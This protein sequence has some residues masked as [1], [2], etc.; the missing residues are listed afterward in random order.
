MFYCVTKRAYRRLDDTS[1]LL[2]TLYGS[3][4]ISVCLLA[5]LR[6]I[7][8]PCRHFLCLVCLYRLCC[9]RLLFAHR[10]QMRLVCPARQSIHLCCISQRTCFLADSQGR[11]YTLFFVCFPGNNYNLHCAIQICKMRKTGVQFALCILRITSC[12]P[13]SAWNEG[14]KK[15]RLCSTKLNRRLCY[16]M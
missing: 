10:P 11:L 1:V 5:A 12:S 15:N 16:M 3:Y 13:L 8:L 14:Y 9:Q 6:L 7:F 2:C 4:P